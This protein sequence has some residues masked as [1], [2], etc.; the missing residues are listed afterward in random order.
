MSVYWKTDI[1]KNAVKCEQREYVIYKKAYEAG[2]RG[3][4]MDRYGQ[5]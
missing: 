5:T 3:I 4:E 2:C 1:Q